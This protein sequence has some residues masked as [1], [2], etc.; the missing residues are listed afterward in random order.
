MNL[1]AEHEVADPALLATRQQILEVAGA[2]FAEVGYRDATVREICHRAGVN[3]AAVNYH[4]G[5]K[6]KLYSA[7]LHY[8]QGR[9]VA[10]YPA[11]L[12]LGPE[13][14]AEEKLRAFVHSFLLRIF[15][16]GPRAWHGKLMSREMV[17]PTAA[18]DSLIAERIRPMA[19]Q[20]RGIVGEILQPPADEETVRLCAL[21]IVSQCVFHHHAKAVLT[22][23][24]PEQPPLDGA[25]VARLADHITRFSLAALRH[26]PQ[27][28]TA[29]NL[30]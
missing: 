26:L 14:P 15:A 2:V 22:R 12:D 17:D 4:F 25:G 20:L 3:I 7:V 13:A 10:E 9:A 11:L 19:D 23:L 21:S 8:S 6:E 30:P 16:P 28:A 1:K 18:L 24:F 27:P 5:D 29:L